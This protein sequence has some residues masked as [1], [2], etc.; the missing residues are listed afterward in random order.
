MFG[1]RLVQSCTLAVV[2]G[3]LRIDRRGG[4]Q[5]A[6]DAAPGPH[7]GLNDAKVLPV[8]NALCRRQGAGQELLAGLFEG[9]EQMLKLR[10]V[11]SHGLG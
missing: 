4:R 9:V 6:L 7:S 8:R 5:Q 2:R 10:L 11:G 3:Q 1:V